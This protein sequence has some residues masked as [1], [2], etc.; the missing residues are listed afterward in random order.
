MVTLLDPEISLLTLLLGDMGTAKRLAK[1]PGGW[2]TLSR[3]ELGQM[4][5]KEAVVDQVLGSV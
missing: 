3:F 2:R 4:K 5:F 1:A